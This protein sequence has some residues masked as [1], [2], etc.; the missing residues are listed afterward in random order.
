MSSLAT[1]VVVSISF[2]LIYKCYDCG[3]CWSPFSLTKVLFGSVQLGAFIYILH[4]L[5]KGLFYLFPQVHHPWDF[6]LLCL[7]MLAQQP[8]VT[9]FELTPR[10]SA[11]SLLVIVWS[12]TSLILGL[13]YMSNLRASLI[14][15]EYEKPIDTVQVMHNYVVGVKSVRFIDRT[16]A[17]C[18]LCCPMGIHSVTL[19]DVLARNDD[20][21][22]IRG[23]SLLENLR[24]S[25]VADMRAIY[26]L[27]VRKS[28]FY[29]YNGLLPIKVKERNP[30]LSC[31]ESRA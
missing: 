4:V 27:V 23:T 17:Q 16:Q 11:G 25:P 28:T 22:Y 18:V 19:Q 10:T 5:L 21:W 29:D 30:P 12:L 13:A 3:K 8:R 14:A 26:D 2:T 31:G 9:W 20:L 7:G 15:V 24:T 1:V 6:V